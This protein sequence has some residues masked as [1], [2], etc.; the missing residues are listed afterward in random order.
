MDERRGAQRHQ[1]TQRRS[2]QIRAKR[3][4]AQQVAEHFTAVRRAEQHRMLRHGVAIVLVVLAASVAFSHLLDHQNAFHLM[5][6]QAV[7]DVLV[8]YPTAL[9]LLIVAAIVAWPRERH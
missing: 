7:E 1:T 4:Y 2:G 3:V 8:G 9:G 6:Q 5:S